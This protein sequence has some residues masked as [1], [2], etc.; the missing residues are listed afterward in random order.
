MLIPT[1][2]NIIT[3]TD[4]RVNTLKLLE[5]VDRTGFRYIFQRSNPRAVILS[6]SEYKDMLDRLED[7]EDQLY[8]QKIEKLPKGKGINLE[9]VAQE[10]ELK[11]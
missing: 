9:D 3:V 11:L 4:M 1:K 6:I 2:Q 10:Y 8:A 7:K 5:D